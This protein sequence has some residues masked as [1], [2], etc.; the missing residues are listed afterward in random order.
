MLG[1]VVVIRHGFRMKS[2]DE[3][4]S[5]DRYKVSNEQREGFA[6]PLPSLTCQ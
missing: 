5:A 2:S 4:A 6:S 1:V 3:I